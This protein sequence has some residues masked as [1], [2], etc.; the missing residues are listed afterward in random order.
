MLSAMAVNARALGL[1]AVVLGSAACGQLLGLDDYGDQ[2]PTTAPSSGS[3]TGASGG[4]GDA[5]GGGN[6]GSGGS[7]QPDLCP[8]IEDC[9]IPICVDDQ[10][11]SKPQSVGEPCNDGPP[12]AHVCDGRG[13]CVECN[14]DGD[15][16]AP[17]VCDQAQNVC[18]ALHCT[19][20]MMDGNETGLDCGGPECAACP[21]GQGCGGP[22][23]CISGFCNAGTCTACMNESQCV[24]GSYCNGGV[25]E[26]QLGD[27]LPCAQQAA[28]V[29]VCSVDGVC[30]N[31]LCDGPCQ[32]CLTQFS[33]AM[34]GTCSPDLPNDPEQNCAADPS[35]CQT[36]NCQGAVCEPASALVVCR[37]AM[38]VCDAPEQCNGNTAGCPPDLNEPPGTTCGFN[39]E[40]ND[41]GQCLNGQGAG[42][43][44]DPECAFPLKCIDGVCCSSLCNQPCQTCNGASPGVCT[45]YGAGT[46]PEGE[47]AW[48]MTCCTGNNSCGAPCI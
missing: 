22:G 13:N 32:S 35:S 2:P 39:L 48:A 23:D 10:C 17:E 6:G 47:C 29:H 9:R 24:S 37:P 46:D 44:G 38:D 1:A 34:T 19:N 45:A 21:N 30:C 5:G 31:Q 41:M 43:M 12:D 11:A 4:G 27:G 8:G 18:I 42:C 3:G 7:C 15:C 33:G 40:C 36:G 20:G 16:T 14:G 25:C 26:P 28:C